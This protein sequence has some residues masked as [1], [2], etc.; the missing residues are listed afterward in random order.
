MLSPE[1]RQLYEQFNEYVRSIPERAG[2]KKSLEVEFR[3]KG[4]HT[5]AGR[6][7]G[8][9]FNTFRRVQAKLRDDLRYPVTTTMT[10]DENMDNR[11]QVGSGKQVNGNE[12]KATIRK[13]TDHQTNQVKWLYKVVLTEIFIGEFNVN[14]AFSLEFLSDRLD[15]LS[16]ATFDG[17]LLTLQNLANYFPPD[18]RTIVRDKQRHS[19]QYGSG[20]IDLT[21]VLSS[22]QS[23]GGPSLVSKTNYEIEMEVS[24]LDDFNIVISTYQLLL[25]LIQNSDHVYHWNPIIIQKSTRQEVMS[26]IN[27][28]RSIPC[29]QMRPS[30]KLDISEE[31]A[32]WEPC[33]MS[34]SSQINRALG[35][36]NVPGLNR[37]LLVQARNLKFA[38]LTYGALVP[39]IFGLS[40]IPSE[41]TDSARDLEGSTVYPIVTPQ[42]RA[43]SQQTD[44]DPDRFYPKLTQAEAPAKPKTIYRVTHKTDGVRKLLIITETDIWFASP[45]NDFNLIYSGLTSETSLFPA[46]L[47]SGR[48]PRLT[49]FDGEY[50]PPSARIPSSFLAEASQSEQSQEQNGQSN[51]LSLK[52]RVG[53]LF[54]I[55][56]NWRP[57]VHWYKIFDCLI[58]DGSP[59][60]HINSHSQRL[61]FA[62][63]LTAYLKNELLYVEVKRFYELPTPSSVFQTVKQ[64]LEEQDQLTVYLRLLDTLSTN[65]TDPT[66]RSQLAALSVTSLNYKTDGLMFIPESTEYNPKSDQL[67]LSSRVLSMYPDLCKW[68]DP[69]EMTIDFK[70]KRVWRTPQTLQ[71]EQGQSTLL[72]SLSS[73]K[74][75][76]QSTEAPKPKQQIILF[77]RSNPGPGNPQIHDIHFV[78]TNFNPL[79]PDMI[80]SDNPITKDLPD[81]SIVEYGYDFEQKKLVPKQQRLDKDLPNSLDVASNNWDWIF[82][83]ISREVISGDQV[84]LAFEYHKRIKQWLYHHA[85]NSLSKNISSQG[86][87]EPTILLEI[88]AGRGGDLR[89]W[90]FYD[91]VIAVDVNA[92]HLEELKRRADLQRRIYQA[93]SEQ[94]ARMGAGYQGKT[95][96]RFPEIITILAGG[97]QTSL[98]VDQ[99]KSYGITSVN[100]VAM[101][102]SMSFFWRYPDDLQGLV[103]TLKA[104]L[105]PGGRLYFLTIDG[106]SLSQVMRPPFPH[107]LANDSLPL[108]PDVQ[109]D[110]IDSRTIRARIPGIVGDQLEGF[111]YLE[112]LTLR[113]P[114][115]RL[116]ELH[117]ADS[118]KFLSIYDLAYTRLY[119]Y[120][121]FEVE[122]LDSLGHKPQYP[123]I[124]SLQAQ[125]IEAG[126]LPEP[127][128][129]P[130]PG[131][132]P[133]FSSEAA[134]PIVNTTIKQNPLPLVQSTPVINLPQLPS[135]SE[136]IPLPQINEVKQTFQL[137]LPNPD[138]AQ[139][140]PAEVILAPKLN[141]IASPPLMPLP[142]L[143][144]VDQAIILPSN[145]MSINPLP[146]NL[147]KT[148]SSAASLPSVTISESP[149]GESK[150]PV[151]SN[152][153]AT[154]MRVIPPM[155]PQQV[156][157]N[158]DH[159]ILITSGKLIGA[160][161]IVSIDEYGSF[162]H[163][164]GKASSPKNYQA[165]PSYGSRV[166]YVRRKRNEFADKLTEVPTHERSKRNY[167]ELFFTQLAAQKGSEIS[168]MPINYS[169]NGVIEWLR[170]SRNVS[171]EIMQYI[172]EYTDYQFLIVRP[173]NTYKWVRTLRVTQKTR[174]IILWETAATLTTYHVDLVELNGRLTSYLDKLPMFP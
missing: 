146:P 19:F 163:C 56:G 93:E 86:R 11:Y 62:D 34:L 115:L 105:R 42:T 30:L 173:D 101:M 130:I 132:M 3:F 53:R 68:K 51:K 5:E 88:G 59:V 7:S 109:F 144:T 22:Q 41:T 156:G 35:L 80:D 31:I 95:R 45:P 28:M 24:N 113:F 25:S 61:G 111:V 148:T 119:S 114:G 91:R 32:R 108:G 160:T 85:S 50:I 171:Y 151:A 161:R 70:I 143:L 164:L 166:E 72:S 57:I 27:L 121:Y 13:Q 2:V 55:D 37:R 118:E 47:F 153:P 131:P 46:G 82:H 12:I 137:P 60:T 104:L 90:L 154:E 141:L 150:F 36:E 145:E 79:P 48:G 103:N 33:W 18:T 98:I 106:R 167:Y 64:L 73:G 84:R 26:K 127:F 65:P 170:S 23:P 138:K 142:S 120:G 133:L 87:Q 149:I 162:F 107:L 17:N 74:L 78:G 16:I 20:H 158:D 39:N 116:K 100:V 169:L 97:Q 147:L 89:S 29:S 4:I 152:Q 136:L 76:E 63:K 110:Y 67:P 124:F 159:R 40:Y 172:A 44:P 38:D 83:P 123:N 1:F 99:L 58:F 8:I 122:T 96:K 81:G 21:Q 140:I 125:A 15:L 77:V 94:M 168:G 134:S 165:N 69:C 139:T 10:T 71:N 66:I 43:L 54:Y 92:E 9:D 49:V 14:L 135:N 112:D 129:E 117:R 75:L 52:D 174:A 126:P 155:D 102:L 6:A 128:P 157:I